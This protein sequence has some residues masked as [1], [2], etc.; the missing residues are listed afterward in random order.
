MSEWVEENYVL[1]PEGSAKPGRYRFTHAAFQ[2]EIFDSLSDPKIN[3]IVLMA[4]SQTVKTQALLCYLAY[5][6]VL[7]P[8]PTLLVSATGEMI[9]SISKTRIAPAIRDNKVL[10]GLFKDARERDSGNTVRSKI[11]PGGSLTL[12]SSNSPSGLASRPIRYLLAD[13]IDRWDSDAGSEGDPLNLAAARTTS[14]FNAKHVYVSSPGEEETSRINQEFK[15]GDQR[16]FYIKCP[17]CQHEQRLVWANVRWTEKAETAR[18]HC[19]KCNYPMNNYE[20]DNAV[21]HGRWIAH[22]TSKVRSYHI[23]SLYSSFISLEQLVEE[24]I[25]RKPYPDQLKT[26]INTRLGETWRN[27]AMNLD[28]IEFMLRLGK[29]TA[30]IVPNQVLVITAG[31]DIQMDRIEMEVLGFGEEQETWSLEYI[32]IHGKPNEPATWLQLKEA[33]KKKYKREDG[34]ELSIAVTCIDTGHSTANVHTFCNTMPGVYPIKG[35]SGIRPIFP[36]KSSASKYGRVFPIG[37][38]V[39]KEQ[40]YSLLQVNN[41]G[42]GFQH[43]PSNYEP[44]YFEMLTAEKYIT[45][46]KNGKPVKKWHLSS[47]KRNEALDCRVYA[48]AARESLQINMKSRKKKLEEKAQQQNLPIEQEPNN[49]I[50]QSTKSINTSKPV[51]RTNNWMSG[52]V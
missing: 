5:I 49:E 42:A 38:D 48:L 22:A 11:F 37:V 20:K 30:D 4:A 26:F 13:E 3:K 33:I 52:I 17:S 39:A 10:Q 46:Y 25:E 44:W 16:Y 36:R 34:V 24:F 35:V 51:R 6:V 40:V 15:R 7:D 28:K 27:E 50:E 2:R 8:A 41:P 31:C 47:G 32:V 21:R 1:S 29:Y 45:T 14:F 18:Y 43:F 12:V 9:D 23:S 19:D